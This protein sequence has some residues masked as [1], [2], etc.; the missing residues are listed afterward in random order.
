MSDRRPAWPPVL[1][2][3]VP[4]R[5]EPSRKSPDPAWAG[6][7]GDAVVLATSPLPPQGRLV[8]IYMWTKAEFMLADI[9]TKFVTPTVFNAI[10]PRMRGIQPIVPSFG[11]NLKKRPRQS[12]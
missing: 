5:P 7:L 10:V 8:M 11:T 3:A 6:T 4:Q 2:E 9:G 1:A 12:D